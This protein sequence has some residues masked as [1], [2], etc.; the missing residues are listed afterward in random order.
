MNQKRIILVSSLLFFVS[1][2]FMIRFQDVK[3][4]SQISSLFIVIFALPSYYSLIRS[5]GTSKGAQILVI[6]S[7]LP[8]IVEGLAV[9]TGFPYGG[10][11]YGDRLGW[12]L[13]DLVPPTI[14]F[15]YLPML[16]GSLK[17]ASKR[18]KELFTF[19]FVAS[20]FNLMVDLV[21]DPAAV[22]IGFWLY[23]KQGFYFGVPLS[24]FIGWLITGF[25]YALIFYQIAGRDSLPLADGVSISLIWIL[26]FWSGYL[27]QVDLF[28]PGLLGLAVLSLLLIEL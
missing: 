11:E 9:R 18:S 14:S 1:S 8:V 3:V 22:D 10:F 2:Y 26:S 27:L 7:I 15:A 23:S 4:F 6:L 19:C 20:I 5:M 13:F 24:N 21:I 12:L 28:I 16:L 25:V 17:F